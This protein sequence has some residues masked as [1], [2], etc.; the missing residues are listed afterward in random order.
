MDVITGKILKLNHWPDGKVI[1]I[2]KEAA[3]Q[4]SAAGLERE[5]VLARLDAV[6]ADHPRCAPTTFA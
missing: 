4:L 3:A 2:A 1:G 5:S 6:R